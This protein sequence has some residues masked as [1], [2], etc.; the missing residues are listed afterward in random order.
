LTFPLSLRGTPLKKPWAISVQI[1]LVLGFV[2]LILFWWQGRGPQKQK[3]EIEVLQFPKP[4]AVQ[5]APKAL[6]LDPPKKE[7]RQVFGRNRNSMTSESPGS[8]D[9]KAGNTVAKDNDD[10]KLQPSD[11]DTLPIPT[12]DYL[13]QRMPKLKSEIRI[14]YPAEAKKN[15]IEGPVVMDI[16]IDKNG[17][18]R[19]TQLVRGPGFGL[20]EAATEALMQFTFEPA[21]TADGPVAVKIRY[22]YRFVLESR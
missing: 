7:Q 2:I 15:N 3:I 18:V 11:A 4:S 6:K 20:N 14:N 8:A 1:H 5:V 22:T 13:V 21:M 12:D 10:L 9:L 19:S 17:R 16:L